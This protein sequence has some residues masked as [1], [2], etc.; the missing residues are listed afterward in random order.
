MRMGRRV[1]PVLLAVSTVVAAACGSTTS[2][3]GRGPTTTKRPEYKV[4]VAGDSISVGLGAELRR[5]AGSGVNVVVIGEEG[6]GMARPEKFDWPARL[7]KLAREF[8]PTVL[9][10]SVGSN[11]S[12]DLLDTNGKVVASSTNKAAWDAEY[13]KRLAASFDAFKD[14]NTKIIWVG[15]VRTAE[16]RIGLVNRRVHKL[17]QTV[18]ATRPW[19]TI[20]DLGAL[21]RSGEGKAERCLKP[22]GVH[23]TTP[24]LDEAAE[25]LAA[26][27]PNAPKSDG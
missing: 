9:V 25:Q 26:M 6:T 17:A 22:D 27:L 13:S 5:P 15:Q 3:D 16:D 24:C 19:V 18:A 14:T 23:L 21:L 1:I 10:F 20:A 2:A 8:P 12:Q 4:T 7:D 11:D